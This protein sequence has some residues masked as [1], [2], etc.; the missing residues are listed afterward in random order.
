MFKNLVLYFCLANLFVSAEDKLKNKLWKIKRTAERSLDKLKKRKYK[1]EDD[2]A[3]QKFIH[4]ALSSSS[5][6][7]EP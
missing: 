7:Y 6:D 4:G 3:G 5:E 2:P 1:Q